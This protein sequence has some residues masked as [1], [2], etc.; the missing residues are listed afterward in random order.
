MKTTFVGHAAILVETK[1][2]R[3]LS[4]PW[5]QGPCFGAQWWIY[6]K[7]SLEAVD[8]APVDYIYV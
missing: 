4:D 7:R 3:I 2:L 8:S 6:P 5:W 1:G